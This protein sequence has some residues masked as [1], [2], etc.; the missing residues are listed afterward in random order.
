MLKKIKLLEKEN[1]LLKKELEEQKS[2]RSPPASIANSKFLFICLLC[3]LCQV[4]PSILSLR[5]PRFDLCEETFLNS[6][7]YK[8]DSEG[9]KTFIRS[10]RQDRHRTMIVH[11]KTFLNKCNTSFNS[12]STTPNSSIIYDVSVRVLLCYFICL[13]YSLETC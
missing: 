6:P 7:L 3:T 9:F 4:G 2:S 11:E 12:V 13:F 1:D 10:S 5:T 8:R